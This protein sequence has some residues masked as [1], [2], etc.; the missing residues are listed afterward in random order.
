M[1]L[2]NPFNGVMPDVLCRHHNN[3]S[4]K[5]ILTVATMVADVLQVVVTV[6][7]DAVDKILTP[8]YSNGHVR[9]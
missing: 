4:V 9:L 7:A 3:T 5:V 1:Y 2:N 8:P 6:V